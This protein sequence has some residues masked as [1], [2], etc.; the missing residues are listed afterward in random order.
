MP[1]AIAAAVTLAV[2]VDVRAEPLDDARKA[3]DAS[4]YA[5]A[6]TLVV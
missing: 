1:A 6:R 3:V 5:T 4:D 2:A